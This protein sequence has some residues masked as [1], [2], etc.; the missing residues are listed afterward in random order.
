MKKKIVFPKEIAYLVHIIILAFAVAMMAEAN[1]GLS[2]I[3]SPAFILSEKMPFDWFTFGMGEYVVQALLFIVFCILIKKVKIVYFFAFLTGVIYGAVLDL[4]R[5][6][7]PWLNPDVTPAGSLP[8]GVRIAFFVCGM[9]LTSLS[10]AL[11]FKT[12]LY[13]QVYDFF[14]KAVSGHFKLDRTKFKRLFDLGC[15]TVAVVM[16]L[17]LFGKFVGVGWGT[18]VVTLVNG[19]LIGWFDKT[20][21]KIF[22]FKAIFPKF[23]KLFDVE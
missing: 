6:L 11:V 18:V 14:V 1:F 9:V 22:E 19:V 17:V 5:A 13:P 20:Y 7:V 15:F 4:W 8:M 2:M 23:E 12:Y 3:V 21:D 10:V 16:T